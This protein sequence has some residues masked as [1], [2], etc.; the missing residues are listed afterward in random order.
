MSSEAS[1]LFYPDNPKRRA[2]V[3][4][5]NGSCAQIVKDTNQLGTHLN[6]VQPVYLSYITQVGRLFGFSTQGVAELVN[7]W[8]I[9][10]LDIPDKSAIASAVAGMEKS[11]SFGSA[12]AD[13]F[14]FG[15]TLG[16]AGLF[17]GSAERDKLNKW[18]AE[19]TNA[20]AKLSA[21]YA[22]TSAQGQVMVVNGKMAANCFQDLVELFIQNGI[23]FQAP[24]S[25]TAVAHDD[26]NTLDARHGEQ[27]A[28]LNDPVVQHIGEAIVGLRVLLDKG[29]DFSSNAAYV[30]IESVITK[31]PGVTLLSLWRLLKSF[32]GSDLKHMQ[33]L[34]PAQLQKMEAEIKRLEATG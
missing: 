5:L 31:V 27:D 26:R 34:D 4:G 17:S 11:V 10:E 13:G 18:I 28:V 33:K 2:E 6:D 14:S 1:D 23:H 7:V 16:I 32:N 3:Q 9:H 30:N 15:I 29:V 19:L 21:L 20:K 22:S 25:F 24:A 12:F 8:H